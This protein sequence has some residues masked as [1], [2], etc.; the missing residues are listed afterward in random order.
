[1]GGGREMSELTPYIGIDEHNESQIYVTPFPLNKISPM[2]LRGKPM[3]FMNVKE[4][5]IETLRS[6][7]EYYKEKKKK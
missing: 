4:D 2:H 3:P 7:R 5:P 1:M 6:V